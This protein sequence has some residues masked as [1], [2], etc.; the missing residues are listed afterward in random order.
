MQGQIG[1]G[2]F[3]TV[4]KGTCTINDVECEVAVKSLIQNSTQQDKIKM[5]QEAAIL[6]QFKHPNIVKLFG[7]IKKGNSV[8][9]IAVRP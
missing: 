9:I 1:V 7:V 2:A 6:G 3:S 4:S 5:L 8:T